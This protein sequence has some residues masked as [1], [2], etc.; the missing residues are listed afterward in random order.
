[1]EP[2]TGL[3]FGLAVAAGLYA[4]GRY[5]LYQPPGEPTSAGSNQD[6]EDC[7]AACQQLQARHSER[8]VATQEWRGAVDAVNS[9]STS[10][11]ALLSTL[12]ILLLAIAVALSNP[13]TAPAAIPLAGAAAAVTAM[14]LI[15]NGI[16]AAAIETRNKA[17][18]NLADACAKEE[19]AKAT[20]RAKCPAEEALKCLDSVATCPW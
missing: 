16:L 10:V 5:V 14:L 7:K 15:M 6:S 18:Q 11:V 1:M 20:M 19:E 12:A 4:L 2:V 17:A 9:Y 13:F 8:C 3:L